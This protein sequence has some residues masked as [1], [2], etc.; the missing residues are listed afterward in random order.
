MTAAK[1]PKPCCILR[2]GWGSSS[3]EKP[4]RICQGCTFNRDASRNT[5]FKIYCILFLPVLGALYTLY[6]LLDPSPNNYNPPVEYPSDFDHP[7][8]SPL[9]N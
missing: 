4:E 8:L 3:Q 1:T 9:P 6:L 2:R 5:P 7:R